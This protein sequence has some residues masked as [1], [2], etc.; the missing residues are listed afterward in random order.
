MTVLH[1]GDGGEIL[2]SYETPVVAHVR[3]AAGAWEYIRVDRY[4]SRTTSGHVSKYLNG[5]KA[6]AVTPEI[7][8]MI[9]EEAR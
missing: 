3:T 4:Y 6:R 2:F 8:Q 7:M 1:L 5:A 9:L